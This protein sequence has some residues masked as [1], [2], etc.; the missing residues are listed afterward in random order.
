M[1]QLK[2]LCRCV[3]IDMGCAGKVAPRPIKAGD[4]PGPY[5]VAADCK[6]DWYGRGCRLRGKSRRRRCRQNDVN[7]TSR[8]LRRESGEPVVMIIGPSVIE[9]DIPSFDVP[10]FTQSF[11]ESSYHRP[12][13][14]RRR[15]TEQADYG[16]RLLTVHDVG[17]SSSCSADQRDELA[18][19]HDPSGPDA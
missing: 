19:F 18:P 10:R 3:N 2:P 12:I 6:N 15:T 7:P 11:L 8:E 14:I 1:Q 9:A 5:G 16:H 17:K 4:K 13:V